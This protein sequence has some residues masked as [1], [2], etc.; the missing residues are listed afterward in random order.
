M[1]VL[2]E[3]DQKAAVVRTMFD[4]IAPSY[5]RMNRIITLGFDQRWR[6]SLIAAL[7]VDGSDTVLDLACGTG[8]FALMARERGARV[9]GLDFAGAMLTAARRRCPDT[10]ALVR[11]DALRLPLADGSATVAVSGFALRNFVAIPPVLEELARVLRPGGRVGLLEVDEPR[12][13]LLRFGHGVYFQRVVPAIGA[14]LS[15]GSAYRYLPASAAYLPDGEG[16]RT[17]LAEA[18]FT[19]IEKRSHLGG[20]AQSIL[21]VRA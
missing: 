8:D 14:L 21:A 12:S 10:V 6:R 18:G 1:Y 13:G 11:G 3:A 17:M 15:D 7:G 2:P 19:S 9:I 20:A 16:L 4:R 5:D